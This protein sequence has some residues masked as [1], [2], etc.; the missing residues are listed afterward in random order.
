MPVWAEQMFNWFGPYND[1]AIASL[2][3]MEEM[4]AYA[5]HE[6]VPGKRKPGGWY[7]PHWQNECGAPQS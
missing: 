6:A 4:M 1:R 7:S 5:T 2:P 3:V